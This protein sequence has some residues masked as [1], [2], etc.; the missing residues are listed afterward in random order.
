MAQIVLKII[1]NE[2]GD[3]LTKFATDNKVNNVSTLIGET[4]TDN[5]GVNGKSFSNGFLSLKDGYLGGQ[6]TKLQSEV[7]KYNGFMFGATDSNGNYELKLSLQGTNLDKIII[8]GDK[9]ANQFPIQAILDEGT[10]YEK[11]I[12]LDDISWAIAFEK[13]S[14]LHT[15]KF[16]KWNRPNYNACFTTMKVM[17]EYLDLDKGWINNIDSLTQSTSNA[18]AIQ[19][20]ALSNS[21]SA[22]IQDLN[23]DLQNY[24]RNNIIANSNVPIEI[25]VNGNKI[26]SHITSDSNYENNTKILNVQLENDIVNLNDNTFKGRDLTDSTNLYIILDDVLK[27]IYSKDDIENMVSSS[28]V[29]GRDNKVG[30]IKQY[31]QSIIIQYPFLKSASYSDTI[32]K[33]CNM[34]QLQFYE[35]DNGK[36]MLISA[37]PIASNAEIA[38]AIKI[39]NMH[40][41]TDLN[42]SI[43]LKNKYDGVDWENSKIVSQIE[44]N[45][46]C[47]SYK[48]NVDDIEYIDENYNNN[49]AFNTVGA[50]SSLSYTFASHTCLLLKYK[51]YSLTIPKKTNYALT[52]ILQMLDG[53]DSENNPYIKYYVTYKKQTGSATAN[54]SDVS[55]KLTPSNTTRTYTSEFSDLVTGAIEN[56]YKYMPDVEDYP[57]CSVT[58]TDLSNNGN[59]GIYTEDENNYYV[60]LKLL[61][62]KEEFSTK[63]RLSSSSTS[64]THLNFAGECAKYVPSKIEMSLYGTKLVFNVENVSASTSGIE[65]AKNTIKLSNSEIMQDNATI[66]TENFADYVKDNILADY[67]YGV[68]S[69]NVDLFAVDYFD[70]NG[71]KVVDFQNGQIIKI[72]DIVFFVGDL[73]QKN[74]QR[75]WRVTGR[76]FTYDG[77]PKLSLELQEIVNIFDD[78]T[79]TE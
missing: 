29:Y 17:V 35:N 27:E 63:S 49:N 4:T 76:R 18:S 68:S 54:L 25:Y 61:V 51:Q 79:I 58:T 67:K 74:Q 65:T 16:T 56:T 10:Q 45:S 46:I 9:N 34:A 15:I 19:Y 12:Y 71:K 28:I 21:G 1:T 55:D 37:R 59:V 36:P 62:S 14:S 22:E 38:N 57:V 78:L 2:G 73:N 75:Y 31:L 6:D 3:V 33:I 20:G 40:K 11:E 30:T 7:A 69:G 32:N 48:T 60:A 26:Q 66:K 50:G 5:D 41:I 43:V 24:I 70:K 52:S 64:S 13:E 39:T 77:S 44:S 42:Q 53:K 72:N 8:N 23:G 47:Y